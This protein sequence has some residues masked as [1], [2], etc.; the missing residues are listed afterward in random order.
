MLTDDHPRVGRV[1]RFDEESSPGFEVEQ[2]IGYPRS[3]PVR[4]KGSGESAGTISPV[5]TVSIKNRV[6]DTGATSIGEELIPVADQGPRWD[7]KFKTYTA[8]AVIDQVDHFAFAEREFFHHDAQ[9]GFFTIHEKFF[10]GLQFFA[11]F[12]P[13]DDLGL[14]YAEFKAFAPHGFN[15]DSKLKFPPSFDKKAVTVISFSHL[16]RY[17]EKRFLY[18]SFTETT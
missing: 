5:F 8:G 18:Q 12:M 4:N 1:T 3:G 9:K 10:N 16:D 14:S 11:F 7:G 2:G 13:K 17:V 6:Q 15:Q